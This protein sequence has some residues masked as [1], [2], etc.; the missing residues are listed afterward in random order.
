MY[1]PKCDMEF[2]DGITTCTDCGGE[3]VDRAVWEQALAIRQKEEAEREAAEQEDKVRQLREKF[4]NMSE[5]NLQE[6]EEARAAIREMV[7][8]PATYKEERDKYT[9]NKSSA[10]ALFF[11]GL[12]LAVFSILLWTKIL[13]LGLVI[14]IASTVFAAACLIG[15]YLTNKHADSMKESIAR[16][17]DY[18]KSVYNAFLEKYSASFIDAHINMSGLTNE[19]IAL[20]R[21]NYIQDQLQIDNDIPDKSFAAAIAED[22]YTAIY[23]SPEAEAPEERTESEPE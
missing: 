1:C 3:L 10:S 12:I 11:V 20:E 16:E 17:E 15:A 14:T 18:R 4:E 6:L 23:E 8:E 5:E 7:V 2:V 13:N 21:L 19:E 22:I 9:D